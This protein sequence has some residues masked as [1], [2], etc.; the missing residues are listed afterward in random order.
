[1]ANGGERKKF[2][3]FRPVASINFQNKKDCNK[4]AKADNILNDLDSSI[5]SDVSYD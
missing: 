1:M 3:E 2:L 4:N 5:L